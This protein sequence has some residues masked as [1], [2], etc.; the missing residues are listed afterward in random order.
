MSEEYLT[1]IQWKD[2]KEFADIWFIKR[3][4]E[5]MNMIDEAV[6][7]VLLLKKEGAGIPLVPLAPVLKMIEEHSWYHPVD[8]NDINELDCCN[9]CEAAYLKE[10]GKYIENWA[11]E[12]GQGCLT[13]VVYDDGPEDYDDVP[14]ADY[15]L[16]DTYELFIVTTLV[17]ALHAALAV[18]DLESA[19]VLLAHIKTCNAYHWYK[20][21][22][23]LELIY[24]STAASVEAMVTKEGY[25]STDGQAA[26]Q[27][28]N[29]YK[30]KIDEIYAEDKRIYKDIEEEK[31]ARAKDEAWGSAMKDISNL[32]KERYP[33]YP[34]FED[35]IRYY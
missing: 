28:Y 20:P 17:Y 30:A 6:S 34:D 21:S 8:I 15:L 23:Y 25:P 24:Q 22:A 16:A 12:T 9:A 33:D 14:S 10:T 3:L 31:E 27:T 4:D 35:R 32:L 13:R 18:V 2:F 1:V 26:G 7:K 19:A 5:T 11:C 29:F